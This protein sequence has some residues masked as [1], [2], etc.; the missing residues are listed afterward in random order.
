MFKSVNVM[1]RKQI[2]LDERQRQAYRLQLEAIQRSA[3]LQ[4]ELERFDGE[5]ITA[6]KVDG[7]NAFTIDPAPPD[8]NEKE[9]D[10]T[11]TTLYLRHDGGIEARSDSYRITP[12]I[13]PAPN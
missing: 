1:T 10:Y 5:E 12:H 8:G 4:L 13:L 2:I 9:R 11:I 7:R 6:S 3:A